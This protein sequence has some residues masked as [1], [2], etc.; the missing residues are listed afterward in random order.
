MY[1]NIYFVCKANL[2][3]G[4]AFSDYKLSLVIPKQTLE[5]FF[6]VIVSLLIRCLLTIMG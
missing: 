2:D 6:L 3:A 4:L 5:L 1:S